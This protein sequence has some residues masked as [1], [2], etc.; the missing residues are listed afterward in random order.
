MKVV[1][2]VYSHNGNVRADVRSALG[3]S[4]GGADVEI[5]EAATAP[6]VLTALEADDIDCLI[7]DAE[8]TPLGGMGL[9]KQ[10]RDE[11]EYCPPI[12]LLVAREVDSWLATW[13]RAEA[14]HV[15][16]IDPLTFPQQVENLVFVDDEA[17]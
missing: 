11:Y 10:I 4:L 8:A 2:L 6:V 17:A 12:L 13:S 3:T 7:L 15:Y 9:A 5:R 16:P 14:I 1:V